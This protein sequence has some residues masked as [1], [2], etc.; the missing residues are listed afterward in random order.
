M[1]TLFFQEVCTENQPHCLK[2]AW[3]CCASSEILAGVKE[4]N[5]MQ[6][7]CVDNYVK[8]SKCKSKA[9]RY[10][11]QNSFTRSLIFIEIIEFTLL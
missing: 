1:E 10:Q 5:S 7:V 9:L 2:P 6:V 4:T 8:T 3:Q 11:Q